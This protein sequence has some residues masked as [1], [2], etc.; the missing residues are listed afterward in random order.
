MCSVLFWYSRLG[1]HALPDFRDNTVA[2]IF[3]SYARKERDKAEAVKNALEALGLSVFF[4]VDGLDGGDA[5]PDVLD[6]EVKN[7]GAVIS[8][9]SPWALTRPWIKIESRIGKDRGVLIPVTIEPLDNLHDVPAAFYDLQQIDLTNFAGNTSDA[10]WISL[11]KSLARTLNR[12]ELLEREAQTHAASSGEAAS[13]RQELNALR[14]QLGHVTAKKMEMMDQ[15]KAREEAFALI[16]DSR[17]VGDYKRFLAHFSDGAETFEAERRIEQLESWAQINHS[18]P[19]IIQSWLDQSRGGV[20]EALAN[21]AMRMKTAARNAQKTS[22]GG[23]RAIIAP[24][25]AVMALVGLGLGGFL[26]DP[27][28]WFRSGEAA[29][30]HVESLTSILDR[31]GITKLTQDLT[32]TDASVRRNARAAIAR[33]L[34]KQDDAALTQAF[35][36]SIPLD[37][38]EKYRLHIGAADA[39]GRMTAP[40]NIKDREAALD[41]LF[42]LR[43]T[44]RKDNDLQDAVDRAEA[45]LRGQP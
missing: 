8:L 28:N 32:S 1:K 4:D 9:W 17:K 33:T 7:A 34:D 15:T 10:G 2:D 5:F 43:R 11:V 37:H 24:L 40:I 14:E 23:S 44:A 22:R 19:D 42:E 21:E 39:L 20:F 36:A 38:P 3:L 16:N 45:N 18:D 12:P 6:K 31:H 29:D 13:L 27:F 25:I 26:V 35:I 30:T 41:K